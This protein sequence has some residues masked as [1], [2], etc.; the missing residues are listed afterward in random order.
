M[1]VRVLRGQPELGVVLAGP[2]GSR[3]IDPE[4]VRLVVT[5][6]PPPPAGGGVSRIVRRGWW[7]YPPLHGGRDEYPPDPGLEPAIVYPCFGA[8]DDGRLIF[9]LDRLFF[10]RP[11]GR[12]IGRVEI[13]GR[14]VAEIDIDYLPR[15]WVLESVEPG[16]PPGSVR[17]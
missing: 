12:Y 7:P 2:T 17:P 16:P 9:R 5:P 3:L 14:A 13:D 4:G 10:D 1:I 8:D 15:R 11:C 6:P